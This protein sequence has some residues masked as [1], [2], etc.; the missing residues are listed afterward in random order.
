MSNQLITPIA[1]VIISEGSKG[2]TGKTNLM[3]SLAEWF[4]ANEI[5]AQLLDLDIENKKR[6][7]L[8]HFFPDTPKI[9]I[10]TPAGLDAFIDYALN[11]ASH[12]IADMGASSG[13]VTKKW[14]DSLYPQ[15]AE[16]GIVF[17]AIGVI[18]EDSASVEGVLQWA[19]QLQSKVSYLIVKNSINQQTNFDYWDNTREAREF[20]KTFNPAVIQMDYRLPELEQAMRNHGVTLGQVAAREVD[21]PE[22]RKGALTMRAQ[23]LRRAIFSEFDRV[24]D[25]LL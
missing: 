23:G 14:F 21:A 4:E 3:V 20:V 10:N 11:G 22:L 8:S 19:S 2:G 7:S 13:D 12:I 9:N 1:R 24:K 17:T 15:V 25:I 18:T 5:P 16:A 6:G